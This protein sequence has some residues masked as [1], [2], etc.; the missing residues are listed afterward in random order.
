MKF[1]VYSSNPPST[2]RRLVRNTVRSETSKAAATCGAVQP[3][4]IL[5]RT[6]GPGDCPGGT[7]AIPDHFSE[8]SL[9]LGA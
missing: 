3:S 8:L 6:R 1:G 2:Y 9:F 7:P 4:S 5:S